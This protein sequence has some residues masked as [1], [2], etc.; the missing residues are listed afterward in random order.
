MEQLD[1]LWTN[2][3]LP[4]IRL[5][6][7][8]SIGLLIA[9]ILEAMRWTKY[10][11]K[12][13][14]P[15]SRI[16]NL[17]D[18]SGAAFAMTF[19]SPASA[20]TLLAHNYE[21]GQMPKKELILSNLFNSLPAY[22]T[23]TPSIFF[24]LWPV[25]GFPTLIY[26]GLTLLAAIFRT[27]LTVFLGYFLLAPKNEGCIP[28]HME[29]QPFILKNVLQKAWK[30]F[31]RRIS[32]IACFTIPIYILMYFLHNQGF[33]KALEQWMGQHMSFLS[34]L[35]PQALGIIALYM[36]AELGAVLSA[37]SFALNDGLLSERALILAL[38]VGN[39]VSTPMRGIRHQLPSYAGFYNPSLALQ[40]VLTN[41]G[42]RAISMIFMTIFYYYMTL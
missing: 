30:I 14:S 33:F 19:V 23:H 18:V 32:K 7:S 35:D 4:L 36:A 38:L 22:L 29:K 15:L 16:A 10:L 34:F 37:A 2:L 12:I 40:L 42:L 41:Q 5:L 27:L 1:T 11:V 24:L 39:I 3:F 21:Q 25:L 26:I 20:N 31:K 28:C 9:T 13:A 8:I 17:S 6:I